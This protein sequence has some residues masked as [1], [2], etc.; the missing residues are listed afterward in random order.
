LNDPSYSIKSPYDAPPGAVLVYGAAPGATDKNSKYGHIEVRTRDGFASDYFSPNA[1]TGAAENGMEGRGRV[2]IGV[3][4]KPENYSRSAVPTIGAPTQA[5]AANKSNGESSAQTPAQ[6]SANSTT[7]LGNL[8]MVYET[9]YK[10]ADY[11]KA[12]ATVS[13]G[14]GDPGGK[15]YGAYQLASKIGKPQDF[16]KHEGATWASE[17]AGMDPTKPGA[18]EAKWKEIAKRKPDAFFKAQH[19]Y[20]KRVHYDKV[21]GK[22]MTATGVDINNLSPAVRDAVWSMSVQHGKAAMLAIDAVKKTQAAGT[23]QNSDALINA[24]Y[25]RREKYAI[26]IGLPNLTKRFEAERAQALRMR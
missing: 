21:V 11:L 3:Y 24:L 18:F 4:T 13:T 16:L 12:A 26:T 9:S 10:P 14:K 5:A 22:V 2:L 15:S 1:R 23:T 20:I 8:S 19:D 17:F 25:D 7:H 6:H